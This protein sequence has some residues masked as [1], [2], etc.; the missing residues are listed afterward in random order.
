MDEATRQSDAPAEEAEQQPGPEEIRSEIEQ[1]RDE[2]GDTFEALA[3]KA[4]VKAQA[5][6]RVETAREKK[7]ELLGKAKAAAPQSATNGL[8]QVQ[9]KAQENPIP[10][11]IGAA[12]L[13]GFLAGRRRRH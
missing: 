2:L 10:F 11:V 12:V 6:E 4:D 13:A 3:R 8:A 5:Q 9:A 1:T 7:D